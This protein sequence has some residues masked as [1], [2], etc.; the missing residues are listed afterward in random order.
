[1]GA[2]N[3]RVTVSGV[4]QVGPSRLVIEGAVG[5]RIDYRVEADVLPYYGLVPRPGAVIVRQRGRTP[6]GEDELRGRVA[7]SYGVGSGRGALVGYRGPASGWPYL[8]AV[9]VAS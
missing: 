8:P 4:V 9:A 1:M 7:A 2:A 5:D 6:H 3:E